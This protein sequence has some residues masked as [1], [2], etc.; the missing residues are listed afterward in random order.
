MLLN[1]VTAIK[2]SIWNGPNL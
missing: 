1:V 2:S